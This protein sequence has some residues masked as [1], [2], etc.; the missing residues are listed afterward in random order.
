VLGHGWANKGWTANTISPTNPGAMLLIGERGE[1]QLVK[2]A[3]LDDGTCA[4]IARYAATLRN[5]VA[6]TPRLRVAA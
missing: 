2:V 6:N 5:A 1:P 4:A 3:Y